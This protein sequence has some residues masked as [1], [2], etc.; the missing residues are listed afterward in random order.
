MS[1]KPKPDKPVKTKLAEFCNDQ[2]EPY[3]GKD[4]TITAAGRGVDGRATSVARRAL[5]IYNLKQGKV[6]KLGRGKQRIGSRIAHA[7]MRKLEGLLKSNDWFESLKPAEQIGLMKHYTAGQAPNPSEA[8]DIGDAIG[9]EGCTLQVTFDTGEQLP[10]V[11]PKK[12]TKPEPCPACLSRERKAKRKALEASLSPEGQAKAAWK[13]RVD[14]APARAAL[15]K[16]H[17]AKRAEREAER[18]KAE[19]EEIARFR[20]AEHKR[21]LR[22]CDGEPDCWVHN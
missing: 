10:V 15:A 4:G 22:K 19:R 11:L 18:E 17:K 13:K 9:S 21:W 7:M 1:N 12:T 6:G 3:V 5:G 16:K 14:S 20:E 2:G 8:L